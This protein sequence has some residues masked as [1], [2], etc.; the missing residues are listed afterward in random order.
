M[1]KHHLRRFLEDRAGNFGLMTAILLPV[2]VGAAGVALDLTNAMQMKNTMQG[3]ADSAALSAASSMADKGLTSS[4]AQEQAKSILAAQI[5]NYTNPA[6]A[7][8]AAETAKSVKDNT[9][10][11]VATTGTATSGQTFD[12]TINSVYKMP[13]NGLSSIMGFKTLNVAV[14]GTARSSTQAQNAL[15]M[16]LVLDRSGSMGEN[17]DTVDST[18]PS[19]CTETKNGKCTKTKT[20]YIIKI[21]ALKIAVGSL[22]DTIKT[23]DPDTKYARLGAVSYNNVMQSPEKLGW[24]TSKVSDYVDDLTSG[25]TTNSGEAMTLA[26][27][28]LNDAAETTAH[29]NKNGQTKPS[30]FIIFMTDGENNISGADAKTKTACAN[31]KTAGIEVYSVAF[32][33]PSAGRSLLNTCATDASHYY[34]ASDAVELV[35]AFKSIGEK[36]SQ[37]GT[38]LTN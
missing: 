18:N 23:A 12:V 35:A 1:T 6:D 10:V 27:T 9:D 28:S 22:L 15:S 30:K 16:Y 7:Q 2:L 31:A 33:A 20:N 3:L 13:L 11:S 36:A 24:G 32:M 19:T 34:D 25:G 26:Y 17:T 38:R 4:Q 37:I 14:A 29:K 5:S 21:D 8:A